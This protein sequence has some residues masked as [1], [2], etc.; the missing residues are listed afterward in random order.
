[1]LHIDRSDAAAAYLLRA[2]YQNR[3]QEYVKIGLTQTSSPNVKP[4]DLEDL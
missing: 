2:S 1:M 3:Q 4:L